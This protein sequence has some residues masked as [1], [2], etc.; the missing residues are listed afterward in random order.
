MKSALHSGEKEWEEQEMR[1]SLKGCTEITMVQLCVMRRENCRESLRETKS[2]E[3]RITKYGVY[4]YWA[5][6]LEKEYF[7]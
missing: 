1:V 2:M 4:L 6:F 7:T 3:G 5:H